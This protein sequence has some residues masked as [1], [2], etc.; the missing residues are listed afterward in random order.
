VPIGHTRKLKL[1]QDIGITSRT[2]FKNVCFHGQTSQNYYFH[3]N[4]ITN[5]WLSTKIDITTKTVQ[6]PLCGLGVALDV[7]DCLQKQL[8]SCKNDYK[9][10]FIRK[11]DYKYP[12][13]VGWMPVRYSFRRELGAKCPL[14]LPLESKMGRFI[15]VT[16]FGCHFRAEYY[17][18]FCSSP[19]IRKL[20]GANACRSTVKPLS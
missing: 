12:Y 20:A 3:E 5:D 16:A 4:I 6:K 9:P 10:R 1:F 19:V 7:G 14:Q 13:R 8:V 2:K 15:L 11:I 17:R 18:A